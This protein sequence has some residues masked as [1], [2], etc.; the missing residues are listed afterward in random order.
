MKKLLSYLLLILIIISVILFQVY[1]ID[2]NNLFGV[3]PNLILVVVIVATLWYDIYKG[4]VLAILLG[5]YLDIL[6]GND[7]MIYTIG[8]FV[9]SCIVGLLTNSYRKENKV[10]VMYLTLLRYFSI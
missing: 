5:I 4:S 8:Y 3:K 6:F 9:T 1:I 2:S 7:I 10:S